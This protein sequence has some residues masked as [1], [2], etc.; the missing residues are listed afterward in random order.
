MIPDS[1][2]VKLQTLAMA[3]QVNETGNGVQLDYYDMKVHRM[4]RILAML[5]IMAVPQFVAGRLLGNPT[6][7]GKVQQ[8]FQYTLWIVS[9][10]TVSNLE[11]RSGAPLNWDNV[12]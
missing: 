6:R 4:K 3:L 11:E 5:C 10:L 12:L 2:A 1:L 7:I 8:H 9:N